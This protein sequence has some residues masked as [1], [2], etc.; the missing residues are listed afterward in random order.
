MGL[1]AEF[2]GTQLQGGG[3]WAGEGEEIL[4]DVPLVR[5]AF[6]AG[7]ERV[8]RR[9]FCGRRREDAETFRA[10][11]NR[12]GC[13]GRRGEWAH[14]ILGI[15]DEGSDFGRKREKLRRRKR[16]RTLEEI[17]FSDKSGDKR[18]QRA[19]VDLGRGADLF[20]VAALEDGEAVG[21]RKGF[22]LVV[23]DVDGG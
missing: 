14:P 20:D 18:I 21:D 23:S 22:F 16:D 13:S 5:E 2:H 11:A 1:R 6:Q 4:S 3:G 10:D 17:C 7:G 12:D 19:A 15:G 8:K 9:R